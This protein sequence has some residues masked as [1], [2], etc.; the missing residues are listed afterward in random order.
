[1]PASAIPIPGRGTRVENAWKQVAWKQ[2]A[3]NLRVLAV[4]AARTYTHP[5]S[6]VVRCTHAVRTPVRPDA[7]QSNAGDRSF[8]RS[9][10]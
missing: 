8:T 1:M 4:L 10:L 6:S 5:G 2:V 9:Q 3:W 7:P